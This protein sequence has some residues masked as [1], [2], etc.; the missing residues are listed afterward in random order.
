MTPLGLP[1]WWPRAIVFEDSDWL[2]IDKPSG[3]L[4][5]NSADLRPDRLPNLSLAGLARLHC[6]LPRI[7]LTHRLDRET[8]GLVLFAKRSTAARLAQLSFAQRMVEKR[9]LAILQGRLSTPI[10]CRWPIRPDPARRGAMREDRGGHGLTAHT[11]FHPLAVGSRH[12]WVEIH[13]LTGRTHQIRVHAKA[14]GHPILGDPLYDPRP[15]PEGDFNNGCAL[16]TRLPLHCHS[17]A[18]LSAALPEKLEAPIPAEILVLAQTLCG[19]AL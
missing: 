8:S 5:H 15:R 10:V 7:H 11:E 3:L 12:T 17:L 14:L 9:Y 4:C 13:P 6:G 2:A 16:P 19:S 18:F 1:L